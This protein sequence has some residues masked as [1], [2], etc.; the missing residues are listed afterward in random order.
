MM[1]HRRIFF[2]AVANSRKISATASRFLEV[3]SSKPLSEGRQKEL[4][5]D[6]K[7]LEWRTKP[8][9]RKDVWYTKFKLL[10]DDDKEVR[11]NLVVKLQRPMDMRPK[12]IKKWWKIKNEEQERFLQQYMPDRH[13]ILGND[14]A[15]AHFLLYRGGKVRFFQHKAWIQPVI[16]EEAKL[17]RTYRA[18]MVLEAIDCEGMEIYYE[19]LENLRRLKYLRFLSFKDVKSFD[20]W[21][22]DRVSGAEFESLE[23][24]NLS[25]TETSHRGLQALYR[26]PSL[27]KLILT[28]PYRDVQWKLTLAMLHDIIPDLE[29]VEVKT[30]DDA[31]K[32]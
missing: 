4:D 32:A 6:K 23:I 5:E 2:A 18:D 27:K 30:G 13:R 15:A 20:D 9:D 21:C 26:V 14:L 1:L 28:N 24:L 22:L 31:E 10:M 8:Y 7:S 3:P 11:E 25:G 19:G 12:S 16:G 17:P 29:I